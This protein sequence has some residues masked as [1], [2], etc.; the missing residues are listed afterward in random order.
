M[1]SKRKETQKGKE[2]CFV[3]LISEIAL[4]MFRFKK[5]HGTPTWA[6]GMPDQLCPLCRSRSVNKYIMSDA[7]I[8]WHCSNCD[9]NWLGSKLHTY[10]FPTEACSLKSAVTIGNLAFCGKSLQKVGSFDPKN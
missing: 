6:T 2:E 1:H 5:A 9:A 4:K 10:G 7:D 8:V 3:G